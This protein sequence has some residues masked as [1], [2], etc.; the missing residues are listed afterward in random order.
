MGKEGAYGMPAMN[1]EQLLPS[2]VEDK[3]IA[4]LILVDL[5][6]VTLNHSS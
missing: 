4:L 1:F 5:L 2:D 3:G 6:G